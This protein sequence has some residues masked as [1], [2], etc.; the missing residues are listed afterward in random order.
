MT[1]DTVS[2]D[3]FDQQLREQMRHLGDSV[4][5]QSEQSKQDFCPTPTAVGLHKFLTA[6]QDA[7][8][9]GVIVGPPGAGKTHA[10]KHYKY[11]R[12]AIYRVE[13]PPNANDQ[14][15][16]LERLCTV[17]DAV[18]V[19]SKSKATR[20]ELA[21]SR[22]RRG[23]QRDDSDWGYGRHGN[24]LLIIDEAQR[25]QDNALELIRSIH[26]QVGGAT[27]LCANPRFE[28]RLFPK[29]N[30]K[31]PHPFPQLA[32]R[33]DRVYRCDD[34]VHGD[35]FDALCEHYR[36]GSKEARDLVWGKVRSPRRLYA[37]RTIINVAHQFVP[38]GS[39]LSADTI[40]NAFEQLSLEM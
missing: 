30:R 33:I 38:R 2:D 25:L 4:S 11:D 5:E 29:V 20:Y 28:S 32:A 36:I 12:G 14:D 26:D 10:L 22:M 31:Q 19:R 6:C 3:D 27:V 24:P 35:D 18:A 39:V 37:F 15:G 34:T 21:V 8:L 9:F 40:R 23:L 7:R 17:L 13:P 1:D 16:F